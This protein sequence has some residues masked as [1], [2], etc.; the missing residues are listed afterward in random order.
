MPT[1]L[2]K[3][4][5]AVRYHSVRGDKQ[6]PTPRLLTIDP[7]TWST[8]TTGGE[9]LPGLSACQSLQRILSSM[10]RGSRTAAPFVPGPVA[11]I[12]TPLDG[13]SSER[14]ILASLAG[15]PASSKGLTQTWGA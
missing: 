9:A 12:R 5:A 10:N 14:S 3:V 6:L 4:K 1:R 11:V 8:D 7:A 13:R 15:Q 2:T